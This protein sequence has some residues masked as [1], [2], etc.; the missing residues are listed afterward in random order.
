MKWKM[1]YL[2]SPIILLLAGFIWIFNNVFL[3]GHVDMSYMWDGTLDET[4]E[5]E[6]ST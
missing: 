1:T 5:K 2:F 3:G 4:D 6:M